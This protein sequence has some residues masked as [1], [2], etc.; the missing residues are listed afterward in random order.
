MTLCFASLG[1]ESERCKI[2][3]KKSFFGEM[4]IFEFYIKDKKLFSM[5][6]YKKHI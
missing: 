1:F 2:Y 6:L 5:P 4:Y 3:D